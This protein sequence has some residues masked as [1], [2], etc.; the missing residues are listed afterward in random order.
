MQ[1]IQKKQKDAKNI[2]NVLHSKPSPA[3]RLKSKQM[4]K[5]REMYPEYFRES[6]LAQMWV[7]GNTR[8][9]MLIYAW[10]PACDSQD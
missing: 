5:A 9:S 2:S 6:S 10:L 3:A 8:T 7:W 1:I 4:A